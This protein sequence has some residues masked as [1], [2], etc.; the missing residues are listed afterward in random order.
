MRVSDAEN[1]VVGDGGERVPR[2]GDNV[3]SVDVLR[4]NV[5]PTLSVPVFDSS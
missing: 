2:V 1:V 5:G 3:Y 4:V